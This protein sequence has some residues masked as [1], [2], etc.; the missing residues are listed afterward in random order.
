[1]YLTHDS[2]VNSDR[3][4]QNKKTLSLNEDEVNNFLSSLSKSWQLSV[5]Y[6]KPS[7]T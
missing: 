4:G 3:I 2:L 6:G 7:L 1:M 5:F